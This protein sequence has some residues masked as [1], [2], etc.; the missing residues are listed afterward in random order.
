MRFS[1]EGIRA[2]VD[3]L[4]DKFEQAFYMVDAQV[5]EIYIKAVMKEDGITREEVLRKIE[6]DPMY[7]MGLKTAIYRNRKKMDLRTSRKVHK[8]RFLDSLTPE[9]RRLYDI[10]PGQGYWKTRKMEKDARKAAE[11]MKG[12]ITNGQI[13]DEDLDAVLEAAT[14]A[15]DESE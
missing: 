11:E 9:E 7:S 10:G 1:K 14:G 2:S 3:G 12:R 6:E 15:A 5:K 8:Q 4:D 13:T